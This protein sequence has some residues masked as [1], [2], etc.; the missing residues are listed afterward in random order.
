MVKM[1]I[2]VRKDLAMGK[3]KIAAQVAHAAVACT[4][5]SMKKN[6]K[7]FNE[8]YETGQKKVVVK[9]DNLEEIYKIKEECKIL[10]VISETIT[11]AGFT[12]IMP[13][14]VTCIGLGPDEDD[15]LDQITGD[16]GLL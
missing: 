7:I 3:G 1:V 11:D 5:I 4:L 13:G 9:V 12:Q 14:S 2:A 6:K 8:W 15:I 10:G 16:Y